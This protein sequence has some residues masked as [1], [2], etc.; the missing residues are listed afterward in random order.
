MWLSA[1]ELME[2]QVSQVNKNRHYNKL[3]SF[4]YKNKSQASRQALASHKYFISRVANNLFYGLEKEFRTIPY[5]LPKAGGS[6]RNTKYISYPLLAV[7]NSIGIYLLELT[8]TFREHSK[9]KFSW[10]GADLDHFYVSTKDGKRSQALFYLPHYKRYQTKLHF[11]QRLEGYEHRAAIYFDIKDF[12][13][14][15]PI[16]ILLELI[17]N[18][19]G[20]DIKLKFRFDQNARYEI[21]RFYRYLQGGNGVPQHELNTVSSFI[22]NL[23]LQFA[24]MKIRDIVGSYGNLIVE[25][26]IVQYVDDTWLFVDFAPWVDKR[27]R[28]YLI[29]EIFERVVDEFLDTY[30]LRFSNKT[31]IF[32]LNDDADRAAMAGQITMTS[33]EFGTLDETGEDTSTPVELFQSICEAV[34]ELGKKRSSLAAISFLERETDVLNH[35]YKK[36]VSELLNQQAN[37]SILEGAFSTFDFALVKSAPLSLTILMSRVKAVWQRFRQYLL[38][39]QHYSSHD[40]I[41]AITYL[42]QIDFDD[43]EILQK[44]CQNRFGKVLVEDFQLSEIPSEQPGYFDVSDMHLLLIRDEHDITRQIERRVLAERRRDFSVAM[45]HLINELEALCFAFDPDRQE[46]IKNYNQ[47]SVQRFIEGH[48]ALRSDLSMIP[49]IYKGRHS[50]S[51]SHPGSYLEPIQTV[52]ENDY[53]RYKGVIGR[54]IKKILQTEHQIASSS[55]G[56]PI[57]VAS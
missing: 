21:E 48:G 36:G 20:S 7:H 2:F 51:V 16:S 33:L 22:S 50:N 11:Q 12:F 23:Y 8:R 5:L 42:G 41:I 26:Q 45:N 54:F 52:L 9:E 18:Y 40:I 32:Y 27:Q 53:L 44:I 29:T 4:S 30:Q 57:A 38:E 6:R 28:D 43:A 25:S 46:S 15:L 19:V 14:E 56:V 3:S 10:Y 37:L 39:K 47:E 35:I 24:N 55:A 13:D 49:A 1:L 17:D 34:K 31:K